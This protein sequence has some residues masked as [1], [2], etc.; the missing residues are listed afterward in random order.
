MLERMQCNIERLRKF[1]LRLSFRFHDFYIFIFVLWYSTEIVFSTTLETIL[2][3]P[4]STL[5]SMLNW[6]IFVL[7]M[8]QILLLLPAYEKRELLIIVGISFPIVIATLLSD[9]KQ[10]LSAWMFIVAAKDESLDRIIHIAYK[11]LM[12]ML[13]IVIILC[14]LGFIEDNTLIMRGVKRYSLGF[15]HPNQLG[16]RVF[17]L[18][19]CH[20]YIYKEKLKTWNYLFIILAIVFIYAIPNSQTACICMII[21]L[22]L[23]LIYK[24]MEKRKPFILEIYTKCLWIGALLMNVLSLILTFIDIKANP[25]L[26]RING[27]MSSRFSHGHKIWMMYGVSF[28]G[29]K[30]YVSEEERKLVDITEKLWLDNAYMSILLRH[31]II[32][33]LIFSIGYLWLI[34]YT[35]MQKQYILVII[36]SLYAI[37]GVMETILYQ[38]AHNIFLLAFAGL[39]YRK[40]DKILYEKNNL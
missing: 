33:F 28:F 29:Q 20:C 3:I 36:L 9:N 8:F 26:A 27:W 19:V 21:L 4:T 10:I 31:G 17:Q 2:G 25:I 38:I 13:P 14:M 30:I 39:L 12:I 37:Y 1:I 11:I 32:V 7:L 6:L 5:N 15:S 34:K 23:L 16:V 24:C 35:S 18:I 22:F 40:G